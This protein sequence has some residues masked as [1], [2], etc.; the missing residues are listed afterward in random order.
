M[1]INISVKVVY[2]VGLAEDKKKLVVYVNYYLQSSG[3]QFHSSETKW[4]W[5]S[6]PAFVPLEQHLNKIWG[7]RFHQTQ[8]CR[9]LKKEINSVSLFRTLGSAYILPLAEINYLLKS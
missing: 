1:Y 9:F 3:Y 5:L 8:D 7:F 2:R 6:K 4:H